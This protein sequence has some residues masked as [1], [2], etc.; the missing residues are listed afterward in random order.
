MWPCPG[1]EPN[2][3]AGGLL[4]VAL[5]DGNASGSYL[6][7]SRTSAEPGQTSTITT[8]QRRNEAGALLRRIL[9][10]W[11]ARRRRVRGPFSKRIGR[12]VLPGRRR[13]QSRLGAGPQQ[14]CDQVLDI[15]DTHGLLEIRVTAYREGALDFRCVAVS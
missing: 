1:L 3:R 7:L 8:P 13:D 4:R 9:W 10:R 12:R 2:G 5:W 15:S 14:F 6:G 11:L